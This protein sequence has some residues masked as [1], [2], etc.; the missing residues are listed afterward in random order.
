MYP[1]EINE[2]LN[3]SNLEYIDIG[4]S[5]AKVTRIVKNNKEYFLK[6][7]TAGTL[8]KEYLALNWL[9]GKINVPKVI[10]FSTYLNK[11]FLLTEKLEGEMLCC[12]E[13]WDFPEQIVKLA[14]DAIAIL[15][16]INYTSCPLSSDLEHKLAIAKYNVDNHLLDLS[17]NSKYF[18][19]FGSYE[20][21]YKFLINNK[22]NEEFCF[23][24][25]DTSL[26]NIFQKNGKISGFLD[27]GE[28]GCADKWFDIAIT[29]KSIRRNFEDEKYVD[30][31]FKHLGI[32]HNKEKVEYYIL[33]MELYL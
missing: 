24:H 32:P 29:V 5:G 21:I 20:E 22:P 17:N 14:A 8:D 28:C 7:S 33:L 3:G 10:Y 25:G 31:F 19:K 1:K 12:D 13:L 18:K 6:E 16:N 26:P 4:C 30:M 9:S 15:Q 2:F 27:V 23:S 11:S